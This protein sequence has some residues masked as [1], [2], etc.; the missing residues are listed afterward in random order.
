MEKKH[1]SISIFVLFPE[2]SF[3]V[4]QVSS[5][6]KEPI[7]SLADAGKTKSM[8]VV[9]AGYLTEMRYDVVDAWSAFVAAPR[10]IQSG[11]MSLTIMLTVS[12]CIKDK[13]P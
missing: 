13:I 9:P 5:R 4:Q 11:S 12:G 1:I 3:V 7:R 10:L 2:G 6:A 8:D